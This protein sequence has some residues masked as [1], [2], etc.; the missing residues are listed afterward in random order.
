M[1]GLRSIFIAISIGI[2]IGVIFGGLKSIFRRTAPSQ[3][4]IEF[5][6]KLV[7]KFA[8]VLKYSTISLLVIGL[9]W[10]IYFLLLGII[11]P[12]QTEYA[13][14]MSELIVSVLTVIS[15]IFAFVEFV[16]RKDEK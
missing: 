12:A 8:A 7:N 16:R 4:Q 3:K 1:Y 13:A 11:V 14:N 10:C 2:I 9:F 6:R 15:I 5:V